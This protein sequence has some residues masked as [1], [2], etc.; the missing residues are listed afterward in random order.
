MY[1]QVDVGTHVIN[2]KCRYADLHRFR[3]FISRALE[4]PWERLRI[5]LHAENVV[6]HVL[7]SQHLDTLLVLSAIGFPQG[8][9]K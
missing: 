7:T 2:C 6:G 4:L 9:M 5:T 8:Y 3:I 1:Y